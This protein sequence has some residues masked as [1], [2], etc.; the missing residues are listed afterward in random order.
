MG[1]DSEAVALLGLPVGCAENGAL[2]RF[3]LE[4]PGLVGWR[5]KV[6]AKVWFAI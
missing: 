3:A 5:A 2:E 1:G 4:E 6:W